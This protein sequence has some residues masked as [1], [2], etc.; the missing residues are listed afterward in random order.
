MLCF[1]VIPS[2]AAV[3]K[4]SATSNRISLSH[5]LLFSFL[6]LC[7]L[8]SCKQVVCHQQQNLTVSRSLLLSHFL[9]TIILSSPDHYSRIA[10]KFLFQKA[11]SM[12]TC[13]SITRMGSQTCFFSDSHVCSNQCLMVCW[14]SNGKEVD[15]GKVTSQDQGANP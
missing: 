2:S 10:G 7:C 15:G 3:N 4:Q 14:S 6:S 8:S 12:S 11:L 1:R 13:D 9:F 5:S